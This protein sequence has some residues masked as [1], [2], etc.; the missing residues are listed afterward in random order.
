[1]NTEYNEYTAHAE[2]CLGLL[3]THNLIEFDEGGLFKI[4][5]KLINTILF[6]SAKHL[7]KT[8]NPS[9]SQINEE[10]M[11]SLDIPVIHHDN[12]VFAVNSLIGTVLDQ[13]PQILLLGIDNPSEEDKKV[14]LSAG[15]I[16]RSGYEELSKN[17][18]LNMSEYR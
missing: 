16:V 12:F 6:T 8:P 5:N 14:S 3:E 15:N 4:N 18:F 1:M 2:E 7:L 13:N 11:R 9:W 17:I 10:I